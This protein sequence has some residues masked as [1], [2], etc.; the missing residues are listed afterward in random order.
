MPNLVVGNQGLGLAIDEGLALQASDNAID[1]IINLLV[2]DSLDGSS[3]VIQKDSE[4]LFII[5]V[6][7]L[8]YVL[9]GVE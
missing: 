6:T 4:A 5:V 9:N 1:G 7:Y 8:K 3:Q 2:G